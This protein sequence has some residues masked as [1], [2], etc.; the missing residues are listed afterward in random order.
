MKG[1]HK[2]S[3]GDDGPIA[4]LAGLA[5]HVREARYR[6]LFEHAPIGILYADATSRYLD[7]N[8]TICRMLGYSRDELIGMT[9]EDIVAPNE[10]PQIAVALAEIDNPSGHHREWR[11][12]RKDG[13]IVVADVTAT[14]FPDGTLLAMIQDV[15]PLRERELT[16]RSEQQFSH[17]M[18]ESMPGIVYFYDLDGRF[19]RWNRNFESVSG[20]SAAEIASMHPLDF[21]APEHKAALEERI[22]EVFARGESSIEAPFLAK[23]GK[24]TPYFFTGRRVIFEGKT[25]LVGV[26]IDVSDRRRAEHGLVESERK[27]RELVEH[28]NSIILRW[29]RDGRVTFLNEFGQRFFGYSAQEIVGKH[30]MGTIVPLEESSGRDLRRLMEDICARPES[31]EQSVNEN[32]RRDGRRAWVAWTNRLVRDASGQVVELLSV[33]SDI[34]EQRRL[35][36]QFRQAQ[37]MEAIGQLAG[38][39]AHD[40]NNILGAILGNVR[41][42]L[43][44][45]V[46]GHPARE[47]LDEI[48]KA[49]LRATNLVQQILA[50]ARQQPQQRRAIDLAP[51]LREA[52]NLLR[53]TIPSVVDLAFEIA[54]NVPHVLADATQV[55]QAVANLCT[56]GWHALEGRPGRVEVRLEA[57]ALDAAAA[58]RI[59]GLKAGRFARL[60]VSDSGKGMDAATLGR[61]FEPFFTTKAPGTGTGLGL[62]VVHGIVRAHDGGIAVSS[63][64]GRGTTFELYFP[65]V[66][67]A[68]TAVITPATAPTTG[69]GQHV[70]YVDDE[71]ALVFLVT[72]LLKR[73]GYRV[74]AFARAAEALDAFRASPRSFDLVVTDLN[75]PGVSGM[76][77]AAQILAVRGDVPV[78]LCSGH[79]TDELRQRAAEAG[80]RE[81][82]YKPHSI[83]DFGTAIGRL[84]EPAP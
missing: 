17:T 6:T 27:Y 73:L 55:Y 19:L 66:D 26:G 71:E 12:K 57:V 77:V 79:V 40:F 10:V 54:P 1:G 34:T 14:K 83:E 48:H 37:K 4:S 75:M 74:S 84:L 50:F 35:E 41:L 18:I 21:F 52:S 78:V 64:V 44:D 9:G 23:D 69:A 51:T 33:G 15:G 22:G 45:T 72:R 58:A 2:R 80:I 24:T 38:G 32:L 46:E 11:F 29:D 67:R 81:V 16:L 82:L 53:A 39:V 25:C 30:V 49:A 13:S 7:A 5:P 62:P 42:A 68:E 60:T 59:E 20:Y 28:A 70:L 56:N 8:E 3:D 76:Q 65:A 63:E 61:I 47:S 43:A 36:D 31:F